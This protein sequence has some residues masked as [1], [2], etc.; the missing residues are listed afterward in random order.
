MVT[1]RIVRSGYGAPPFLNAA[2]PNNRAAMAQG[3]PIIEVGGKLQF[4]LP[5]LPIFPA[6]GDDTI[7]KPAL[8]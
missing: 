7:L 8:D 4:S 1:G 2:Y 5:G 6:L 3:Q